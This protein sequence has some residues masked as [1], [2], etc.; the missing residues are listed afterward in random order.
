[1][2][3]ESEFQRKPDLVIGIAAALGTP[4]EAATAFLEQALTHAGY[5]AK[6]LHL[7]HYIERFDLGVSSP[8]TSN[9]SYVTELETNIELGSEAR[10]IKNR[11]DVLALTAIADIRASR[12]REGDAKRPNAVVLC[13]LKNP[14]EVFLLRKVYGDIFIALGLYM[15]LAKRE[16]HLIDRGIPEGE[17]ARWIACDE[18]EGH[19]SGQRF[20]DTFHLSDAFV[21]F[22]KCGEFKQELSRLLSLILGT[23]IV[24]PKK[25]EFAMFQAYGAALRSAQLGRQVGAAILSENGDLISVGTNEVPKGGGGTYWEGDNP[26]E[27]D[28][29]RGY[30]SNDVMKTKLTDDIIKNL[31]KE[32]LLAECVDDNDIHTALSHSEVRSLIEFGRAVH[33]EA[34]AFGAALRLGV[35]PVG[36]SLYCTTFPCHLCALQIIAAG[37]RDVT[38]IEPFPK[39]LASGLHNDAIALEKAVTGKVLFKPFVGIAPRRYS[40][41]FA[42]SDPFGRKIERKDSKGIVKLDLNHPRVCMSPKEILDRELEEVNQLAK[43]SIYN[44]PGE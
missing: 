6:T 19:D 27:R 38:F 36:A 1:M 39:S 12:L 30:D 10:R 29:K 44:N 2:P 18:H 23:D 13:Q 28:H 7:S 43:I 22:G 26:D 21:E 33:A 11:D 40:Q 17:V 35:S 4:L 25:E 20:R 14:A 5:S 8:D 9:A 34:D 42:A 37:I 15:P 16:R 3:S 32:E 31:R 24:A 41:F